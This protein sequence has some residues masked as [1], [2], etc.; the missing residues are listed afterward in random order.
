MRVEGKGKSE[1][2]RKLKLSIDNSPLLILNSQ[3][4]IPSATLS[5]LLSLHPVFP[6]LQ[7]RFPITNY[8]LPI[9]HYPL[10]ITNSQLPI[11]DLE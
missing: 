1:E 8:Q 10:P 7:H 4:S 9:T 2:A 11:T 5:Q 3:F 6:S